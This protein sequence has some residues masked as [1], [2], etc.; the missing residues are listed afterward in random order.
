M[1]MLIYA[2]LLAAALAAPV[3]RTD[4]GKLRPVE[5][6]A[7]ARTERG[8]IVRTD[9]GDQGMGRTLKAAFCDLEDTTAGVIYFDTAE[10]LLMETEIEDEKLL[11]ELLRS[12]IRVCA[13]EAEIPLEGSGAYLDIH[14]PQNRLRDSVDYQKLEILWTDGERFHLE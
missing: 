4:V 8:Y 3:E 6:V 14:H 7:V 13:A 2:A 10:Y 5:V 9:T 12:S 11:R 1:K